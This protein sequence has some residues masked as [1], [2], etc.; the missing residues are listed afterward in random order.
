MKSR[1][2]LTEQEELDPEEQVERDILRFGLREEEER[3]HVEEG[4]Y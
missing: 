3:E 4:G 2:R 1:W